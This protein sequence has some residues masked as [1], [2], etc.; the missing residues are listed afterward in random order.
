LVTRYR[1]NKKSLKNYH[2]N[3]DLTFLFFQKTFFAIRGMFHV[4]LPIILFA[5]YAESTIV[6]FNT[7][8]LLM[9]FIF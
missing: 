9:F 8:N 3:N 5:D 6:R 2:K 1:N 7:L 4:F